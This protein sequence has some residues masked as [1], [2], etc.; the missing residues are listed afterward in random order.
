MPFYKDFFYKIYENK[1]ADKRLIFLH[2]WGLNHLSLELIASYFKGK[3]E[4][5]LIDQYGCGRSNQP[6]ISMDSN[7]YAELYYNFLAR[8]DKKQNI[9]VGHSYG[10]RII[11]QISSKYPD[12]IN[13]AVYIAGAGLK[14]KRSFIF[15]IKSRILKFIGISAEIADFICKTN[16]KSKFANKFGSSDYRS[17]KGLMREI[18][19]KAVNED[20]SSKLDLIK[21]P[22]LLIY[23][24]QDNVTPLSFGEKFAKSIRNSNLV[25]IENADHNSIISNAYPQLQNLIENFIEN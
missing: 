2:G 15:K 3:Y 11:I 23:G 13:K 21:C 8:L 9:F 19:V 16:L 4:V 10:A 14:R 12:F 20:L 1:N 7:Q 24:A 22:T 5:I 18:L 6:K 17:A 25:I